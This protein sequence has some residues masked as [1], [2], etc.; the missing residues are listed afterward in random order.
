MMLVAA[1]A[2]IVIVMMLMAAFAFVVVVVV[3][4]AA[5]RAGIVLHFMGQLRQ[6]GR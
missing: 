1:T 4:S 2:F 3:M 5:D 6:F